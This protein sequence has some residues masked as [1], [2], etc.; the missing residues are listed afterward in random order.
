MCQ[1][2]CTWAVFY[3]FITELYAISVLDYPTRDP[4]VSFL[5]LA[6]CYH[7]FIPSVNHRWCFPFVVFVAPFSSGIYHSCYTSDHEAIGMKPFPCSFYFCF[8]GGFS[9]TKFLFWCLG[10]IKEV[11]EVPTSSRSLDRSCF[12]YNHCE[13]ISS[14]IHYFGE[15]DINEVLSN[16]LNFTLKIIY[17]FAIGLVNQNLPPKNSD[18]VYHLLKSRNIFSP[19]GRSLTDVTDTELKHVH[20]PLLHIFVGP[21]SIT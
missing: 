9:L 5:S 18:L 2:G 11:L 1:T 3:L 21:V 12:G 20:N 15:N 4:L 13:N 6:L 17:I 7:S 19:I 16:L 10:K 14:T 8:C